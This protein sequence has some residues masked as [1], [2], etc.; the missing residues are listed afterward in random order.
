[1]FDYKKLKDEAV[2][3]AKL[4]GQAVKLKESQEGRR[5]ADCVSDLG[6]NTEELPKPVMAK[7]KVEQKYEIMQ[8][9]E[10]NT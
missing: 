6:V 7:K 8:K 10:T 3:N 2:D 9:T 1:M 4:K 5:L